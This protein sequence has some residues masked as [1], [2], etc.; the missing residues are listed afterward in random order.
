MPFAI[1]YSIKRI[2]ISI[3]ISSTEAEMDFSVMNDIVTGERNK[4]TVSHLFSLMTIKIIGKPMK[5]WELVQFVLSYHRLT[6]DTRVRPTTELNPL[7]NEMAIW[8]LFQ[9]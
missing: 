6:T 4:L 1:S 5:E 8:S 7:V 3:T 9:R 2:A